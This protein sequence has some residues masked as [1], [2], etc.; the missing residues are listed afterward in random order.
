MYCEN[1]G[2]RVDFDD[3]KCPDCGIEIEEIEYCGGFWGLIGEKKHETEQKTIKSVENEVEIERT[4]E[5]SSVSMKEID[6]KTSTK[7]LKSKRENKK[8]NH[9]VAF[10]VAIIFLL[11]V[12]LIQTVRISSASRKADMY[13]NT[14]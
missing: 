13:Q 1:C 9:S 6:T 11:S 8:G 5:K 12:C 3:K 4:Q 2:R 7:A 14:F 10:V